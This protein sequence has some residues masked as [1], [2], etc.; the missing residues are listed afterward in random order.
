MNIQKEKFVVF[1]RETGGLIKILFSRYLDI[2]SEKD[3]RDG[4]T[5]VRPEKFYNYLRSHPELRK[6]SL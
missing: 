6:N 1:D 3:E 2:V 5:V 4:V